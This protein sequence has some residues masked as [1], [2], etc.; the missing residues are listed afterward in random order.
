MSLSPDYL[1]YPRRRHGMDHDRYAWSMLAQR[2]PVAW[3][4]S[5]PLAL[6]LNLSLEHFPLN[7]A[8]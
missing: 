3:P 5:K 6:W 7:P 2:A 1:A 4:G 8:G